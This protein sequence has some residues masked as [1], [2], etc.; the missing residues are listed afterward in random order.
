MPPGFCSFF[1]KTALKLLFITSFHSQNA[2][3]TDQEENI[4]KFIFE[5]RVNHI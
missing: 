5:E 4:F 3:I 2:P 1:V